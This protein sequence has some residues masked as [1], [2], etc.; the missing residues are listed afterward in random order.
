MSMCFKLVCVGDQG[1]RKGHL[2]CQRRP[3]RM[4]LLSFDRIK[5]SIEKDSPMKFWF[6]NFRL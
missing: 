3:D 1:E 5:K 6:V 4:E 2:F